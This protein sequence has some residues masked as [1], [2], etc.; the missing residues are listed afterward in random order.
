MTWD[1]EQSGEEVGDLQMQLANAL[2]LATGA[3]PTAPQALE[4]KRQKFSDSPDLSRF[5]RTQ[6]RG[7]IAQLRIADS[8]QTNQLP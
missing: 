1:A 6:S 8:T 7:W 3:A 4:V 2:M 5:R